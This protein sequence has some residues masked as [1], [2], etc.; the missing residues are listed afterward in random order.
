MQKR[1]YARLVNEGIRFVEWVLLTEFG[2]STIMQQLV[3][4]RHAHK[5]CHWGVYD[6]DV[7]FGFTMF[8]PVFAIT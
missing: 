5:H 2:S 4:H 7:P 1:M 8:I 3:Q 6:L